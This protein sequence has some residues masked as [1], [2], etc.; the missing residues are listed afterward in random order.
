MMPGFPLLATNN[1]KSTECYPDVNLIL[2][3]TKNQIQRRV[4]HTAAVN[5][6]DIGN[7]G[8]VCCSS[9]VF[10]T[11]Q[12][13]VIGCTEK[14]YSVMS[15]LLESQIERCISCTCILLSTTTKTMGFFSA[16]IPHAS[17]PATH[18]TGTST[19]SSPHELAKQE[20]ADTDV[21]SGRKKMA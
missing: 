16:V 10:P 9:S 1:P 7:S 5:I 13:V 12:T 21:K 20:T 3:L 14:L 19:P 17:H 11:L 18:P 6:Q 8:K 15:P 4:P 2:C